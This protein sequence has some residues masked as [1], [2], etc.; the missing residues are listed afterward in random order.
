MTS[1]ATVR[2]IGWKYVTFAVFSGLAAIFATWIEYEWIR[3]WSNT[4]LMY[5]PVVLSLLAT[6][7][8]I[9]GLF[10]LWI[11]TRRS[12]HVEITS[13]ICISVCVFAFLVEIQPIAAGNNDSGEVF[14]FVFLPGVWIAAHAILCRRKLKIVHR[15]EVTPWQR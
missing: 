15:S 13:S 10:P 2:I 4:L 11:R 6:C 3:G 5:A 8:L 1:N 14:P 9:G 7:A 12:L